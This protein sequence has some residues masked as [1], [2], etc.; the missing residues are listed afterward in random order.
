V[1]RLV[2]LG[3]PAAGKG[4][5]AGKLSL[6]YQ[7]PHISTGELF[8]N[9][10]KEGTPLGKKAK[11]YMDKGELV[12]DQ[13]V[14]EMVEE[15][16]S[17]EDCQK[18]FLLDGY[19]RTVYQAEQLDRY[20]AEKGVAIDKTIDMSVD[21]D[22]TLA[23]MLGRRVCKTCGAIYHV[24]N[25]PPKEEGVCDVCGGPLYQRVDDNEETVKVRFRIYREETNPLVDYYK[26]T[27]TLVQIDGNGEWQRAYTAA[28][29]ILGA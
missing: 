9:K 27:G 3:P 20:L 28:L 22:V 11:E 5:L 16:L 12:P 13:L 6:K 17:A 7:I 8:R 15:R 10:I 19:P 4:T 14:I 23:R 26:K 1:F 18:G 24:T 21:Q 29:A 2:L 25:M